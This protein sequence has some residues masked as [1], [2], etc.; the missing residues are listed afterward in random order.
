MDGRYGN[1]R[2]RGGEDNSGKSKNGLFGREDSRRQA[3]GPGQNERGDY[4]QGSYNDQ[5]NE[6]GSYDRQPND[7]YRGAPE[8]PNG[9]R[10]ENGPTPSGLSPWLSVWIHPRRVTRD[11]MH[12]SN[13]LRNALWLAI[14]AGM[15]NALN[16]ASTRNL[17]D[18]MSGAGI[19]MT[20]LITGILTGLGTYYIGAWLLKLVGGWLG[21]VA[22]T[23]DMRIVSGRI[24]GMLGIMVG[25][26]WIPEL[27]IAGMENFT[28]LTPNLDESLIRSLIYF[29]IILLEFAFGVWSFVLILHATGEVHRFSAWKALL[30]FVITGALAILVFV[31]I[32]FVIALLTGGVFGLF[33]L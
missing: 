5:S 13:P 6:S 30:T 31:A 25:L 18:Q 8:R 16:T 7:P 21:G 32:V 19:A 23:R 33:G 10:P 15:F 14:I 22:S 11:F 9:R 26:F 20:V 28:Y 1:N 3:P 17:G 27:L 2:E 4:G 29:A 12:S 24:V